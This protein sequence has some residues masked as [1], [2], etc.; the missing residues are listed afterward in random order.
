[1][2]EQGEPDRHAVKLCEKRL[3]PGRL[4][5]PVTENVGLGEFDRLDRLV[6]VHGKRPD[7]LDDRGRIVWNGGSDAFFCHRFTLLWSLLIVVQGLTR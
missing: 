5:E 1:M 3:E 6:L 2:K 4:A 7:E